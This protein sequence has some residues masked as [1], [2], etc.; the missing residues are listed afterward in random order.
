MYTIDE[1]RNKYDAL[2]LP[3]KTSFW[4]LASSIIQKGATYLSTPLFTRLMSKDA[5]GVVAVYNSWSAIF[6]I[7]GSFQLASGVLNKALEKYSDNREN[8]TLSMLVLSV[9]SSSILLFLCLVTYRVLSNFMELPRYMLLLMF[10]D[11][12]FTS[13]MSLFSVRERFEFRYETIIILSISANVCAIIMSLV[14]ALFLKNKALGRILG[15]VIVHAIFYSYAIYVIIKRSN[16]LPNMKYWKY[17]LKYNAPLI[18]HYLSQQVLSSADAIMIGALL[19]T[20]YTAVYSLSYQLS[21]MMSVVTSAIHATFVPWT[22]QNIKAGNT[23]VI[24]RRTLQIVFFVAIMCLY[25]TFLAPELVYIVGGKVYM[26][27]IYVIPAASMGVFFLMLYS[28][29]ANIEYYYEKTIFVMIAS[30]IV[31]V[32]NI[33][34]NYIFIPVFGYITAGYTT[35]VCYAIYSISHY[36]FMIKTCKEVKVDNPYSGKKIWGIAL[37]YAIASI[38]VSFTY[39]HNALRYAIIVILTSGLILFIRRNR[40]LLEK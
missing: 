38:S 21:M 16:R 19:G 35:F 26:N 23:K 2:S 36:L 30:G 24:G 40:N 3:L 4:F 28:F 29:F 14:F 37:I 15:V 5:Y 1:F 31:A 33:V 9:T 32:L 34:L 6:S 22:F 12:I 7:I 17:A 27:A 18:P 11:A 39:R 25:G 8:F 20:E 13:S 10:I